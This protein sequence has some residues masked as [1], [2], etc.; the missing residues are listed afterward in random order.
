MGSQAARTVVQ[1]MRNKGESKMFLKRFHLKGLGHRV[2]KPVRMTEHDL[3]TRSA[4]GAVVI[5][6]RLGMEFA[7][8]HFPGSLNIGLGGRMFAACVGAFLPKQTQILLVVNQEEAANG[9]QA[10]LARA[11]FDNLAGFVEAGELTVLHQLTQL[12]PFDLNS[13][14]CRGGKPAILDVRTTADWNLNAIY[15]SR[16]IPLAQLAARVLEHSFSDPLVVVCQDGYQSI[17]AASW[18]Q[19]NGFDSVHHLIGGMD[20]YSGT[21]FKEPTESF[22]FCTLQSDSIGYRA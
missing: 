1:L 21:P 2:S 9:A 7:E 19:A 15:G 17:V 4:S 14:L 18:L 11:G 5:D 20:A 13:T 3:K 22:N 8:G 16:N 6:V 12:S 10:E